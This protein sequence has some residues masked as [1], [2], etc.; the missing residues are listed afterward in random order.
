MS[1]AFAGLEMVI[2]KKFPMNVRALR[3]V[4]LELLRGYIDDEIPSYT[5]FNTFLDTISNRNILAE[6]WVNNLIKP[7]IVMMLYI[8]AERISE[9]SL[10]FMFVRK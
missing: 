4:T 7:V 2:G 6:H 9:F 8:R 1:S 3:Q 10:H 5:E